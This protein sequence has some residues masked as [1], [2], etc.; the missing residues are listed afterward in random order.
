[1]A[2]ARCTALPENDNRKV[3]RNTFVVTPAKMIHKSAKSTSA[4][5][6]GSWV[7]GTNTSPSDR[8]AAAQISTRRTRT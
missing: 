8:S 7:C 4:S 5:A 6:P 2:N 3:N 1:M